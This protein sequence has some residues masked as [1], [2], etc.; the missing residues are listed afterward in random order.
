MADEQKTPHEQDDQNWLRR[1]IRKLR[2]L[3]R[4]NVVIAQVG[5]GARNVV[6]GTRNVQINIGDRNLTLPVLAVPLLLLA[7]Y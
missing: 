5:Q 3:R 1:Q 7:V 2:D 6:I 4:R